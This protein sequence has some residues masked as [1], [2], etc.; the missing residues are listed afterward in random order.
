MDRYDTRG[1]VEAALRHDLPGPA[2]HVRVR[3]FGGK[4]RDDEGDA[5]ENATPKIRWQA[6]SEVRKSW[7]FQDRPLAARRPEDYAR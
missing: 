6:F 5:G 4:G 1:G 3:G 7:M 2:R